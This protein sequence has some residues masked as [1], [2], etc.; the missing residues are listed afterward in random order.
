MAKFLK[1]SEYNSLKGKAD[2]FDMIVQ[3]IIKANEGLKPEDIT[4]QM[5]TDAFNDGLA[6]SGIQEQLN[7]ANERIKTLETENATI[8]TLQEQIKNLQG[9]AAEDPVDIAS[10][11]EANSKPQDLATY[12]SKAD[13][14]SLDM[15]G[16]LEKEGLNYTRK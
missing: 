10:K 6:D 8:P 5:I 12:C 4:P 1:E 9:S 2:N 11:E 16:F 15:I 14:S 7:T 3:S 13:V